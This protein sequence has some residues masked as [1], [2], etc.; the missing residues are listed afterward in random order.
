MFIRSKIS[1]TDSL[2]T[3]LPYTKDVNL[4]TVSAWTGYY[5]VFSYSD[6]GIDISKV[7]VLGATFI[8]YSYTSGTLTLCA[9]DSHFS[10][11]CSNASTTANSVQIRFI[12]QD[13][14]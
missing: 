6:I 7:K 1:L 14:A 9:S 2:A 11:C 4:G 13:I 8:N 3:S 5:V 12:L 10:I